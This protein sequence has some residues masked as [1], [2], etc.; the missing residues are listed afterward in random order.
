MTAILF[1]S[2]DVLFSMW[3]WHASD[4]AKFTA[5][6]YAKRKVSIRAYF[7]NNIQCSSHDDTYINTKKFG[8]NSVKC[9]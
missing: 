8:G 6:T 1:I 9:S 5:F 3:I 7:Y 4:Y 2:K